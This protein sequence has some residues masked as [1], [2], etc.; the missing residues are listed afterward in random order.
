VTESDVA[1][2]EEKTDWI[3]AV[4]P[5]LFVFDREGLSNEFPAA[6]VALVPSFNCEFEKQVFDQSTTCGTGIHAQLGVLLHDCLWR[7]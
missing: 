3:L 2:V 1:Q 6:P 4:E 5:G 7:L